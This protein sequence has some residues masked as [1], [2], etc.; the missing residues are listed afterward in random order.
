MRCI[1]Q[2]ASSWFSS[3][4]TKN[5]FQYLYHS[6]AT[7]R[8]VHRNSLDTVQSLLVVVVKTK[9]SWLSIVKQRNDNVCIVLCDTKKQPTLSAVTA[10][11]GSKFQSPGNKSWGKSGMVVSYGMVWY[12]TT[13]PPYHHH[14]TP[15]TPCTTKIIYPNSVGELLSEPLSRARNNPEP[16][17]MP[18]EETFLS[19]TE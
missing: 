5:S 10:H 4:V 11:S 6:T 18:R 15:S 8:P 12:G 2:S 19:T 9:Q 16:Q 1:V 3:K 7:N 13:R 17:M 14:P